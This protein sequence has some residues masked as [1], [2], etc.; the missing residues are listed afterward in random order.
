[1]SERLTDGQIASAFENLEH[2]EERFNEGGKIEITNRYFDQMR[3]IL[4]DLHYYKQQY[5]EEKASHNFHVTQ[6]I[7]AEKL[8]E[9]RGKALEWYADIHNYRGV[10]NN[11]YL[12]IAFSDIESDEGERARKALE[13]KP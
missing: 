5:E 1:M 8:A 13:D 7:A 4:N 11:G 10:D 3:L 6:L 9:E 12:D 2:F